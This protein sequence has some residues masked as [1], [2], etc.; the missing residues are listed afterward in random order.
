RHFAGRVASGLARLRRSGDLCK[1]QN[2][3]VAPWPVVSS[4]GHVLEIGEDRH[5]REELLSRNGIHDP[6]LS[7]TRVAAATAF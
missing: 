6:T 2:P 7:Q 5:W 3:A 1:R 4:I